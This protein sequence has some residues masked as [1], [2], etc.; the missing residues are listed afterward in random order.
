MITKASYSQ[1]LDNR[2]VLCPENLDHLIAKFSSKSLVFKVAVDRKLYYG[3]DC[4]NGEVTIN[5]DQVNELLMIKVQLSCRMRWRYGDSSSI[6]TIYR[7]R[8][9]LALKYRLEQGLNKIPF[10]FTL[11][12]E[13]LNSLEHNQVNVSWDARLLSYEEASN[14]DTVAYTRFHVSS[15]YYSN[16]VTP[17]TQG[18]ISSFT[19]NTVTVRAEAS[20]QQDVH[21][22]GE[23]VHC[24]IELLKLQANTKVRRVKATLKQHVT[25][26]FKNDHMDRTSVIDTATVGHVSRLSNWEHVARDSKVLGISLDVGLMADVPKKLKSSVAVQKH[27]RDR[28][29][30]T[31][32]TCIFGTSNSPGLL[33]SYSVEVCIETSTGADLVL[34]VP[35]TLQ[36]STDNT[37]LP[38][39]NLEECLT[40]ALTN[41]EPPIYDDYICESESTFSPIHSTSI[42][43]NAIIS[44]NDESGED[45]PNSRSSFPIPG[46]PSLMKRLRSY[47]RSKP[48]KKK[49]TMN[50]APDISA[51]NLVQT[52]T[53]K[54]LI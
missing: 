10:A 11:P 39:E 24:H 23:P 21:V 32:S 12:T 46:N 26:H 50:Y 8:K 53:Y 30:L 16:F 54:S 48:R 43:I 44:D 29:H 47:S 34:S 45:K 28:M 5:S 25:S 15:L 20:L 14:M 17:R 27:K 22:A 2:N 33:V 4:V 41:D 49:I 9:T 37:P 40:F 3:N 42:E 13:V 6:Y 18:E 35:F 19:K 38:V 51:T 36:G 7:E 1:G 31:P 52:S